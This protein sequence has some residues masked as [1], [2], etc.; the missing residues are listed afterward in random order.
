MNIFNGPLWN[1]ILQILRDPVFGLTFSIILTILAARVVR[2]V[3]KV[4]FG[5]GA[6]VAFVWLVT[7]NKSFADICIAIVS[8]VFNIL[9]VLIV[10]VAIV[11]V[12]AIICVFIMFVI[13][14]PSAYRR[15]LPSSWNDFSSFGETEEGLSPGREAEIR[16]KLAVGHISAEHAKVLLS[17]KLRRIV[18]LIY[19]LTHIFEYLK[20]K[21]NEERSLRCFIGKPLAYFPG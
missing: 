11:S 1:S 15:R 16:A 19:Y 14:K 7:H 9:L 12:V 20:N 18:M 21:L 5:L 10:V 17:E 4:I 8:A 3:I 6:L 13:S 2:R